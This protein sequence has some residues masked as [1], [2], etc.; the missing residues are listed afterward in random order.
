MTQK[1]SLFLS[2][3]VTI[4]V[5]AIILLSTIP[6]GIFAVHIYETDSIDMH[7][8]RAIAIA[9]S[10]ASLINPDEFLLALETGEKNQYYMELQQK[11]N[12]AKS[13][14][15]ALFLFSG[16]A[17]NRGDF[18]AFMQGLTPTCIPVVGFGDVIPSEAGVFPPELM[19]AQRGLAV[20]TGI[21]P[22]GVDENYIVAAY[23]PIFNQNGSPIGIV[24]VNILATEV[25]QKGNNFAL[26]ITL[27]VVVVIAILVWIPIFWVKKY[28][29]KPLDDLK[30]AAQQISD[31]NL[32]ANFDTNRNDEIGILS[33]AFSSMQT[34]ISN[35]M[36]EIEITNQEIS[37]GNLVRSN[38]RFSAKGD[39]QKMLD[40]IENIAENTSMYLDC[41]SCGIV[42]FDLE[43]RFAFIN[44]YNRNQGFDPAFMLGKTINEVLPPAEANFIGGKLKES[45][46]KGITVS[47]PIDMPLPDGTVIHSE[48]T[49]MPI[50]NA[51]GKTI[52]YMN[53]AN[54]VT[55]RV[56]AESRSN[57]I[58]AYQASAADS[59]TQVLTDGLAKGVLQFD[60][61]L[62]AYD[63]DTASSSA[64]Y[65]QIGDM[66]DQFTKKIGGCVSEI[67]HLL[68]EFASEN[69]DVSM[70]AEYIGDF[71]I[72]KQSLEKVTQSIGMLVSEIQNST[73]QLETGAFQISQ[74]T[75]SLMSSFEEQATTMNQVKDAV[76]TL[77]E[78]TQ[79]NAGDAKNASGLSEQVQEVANTGSQH[80]Q[81]MSTLMEEIKLSSA[82]IGKVATIIEDIAFQ[83]NLLALN[84]S[85]EAA[86]AGE[87]GKG[88]AVVAEEVRNL[89]GRSSEAARNTA[90]M[91]AKSLN[92]VN[93]GVA[94]SEETAEALNKILKV[95]SSVTEVISSIARASNEQAEEISIIQNSIEAIHKSAADNA[96]AVQSNASVSEELSSQANILTALVDRFKI[97]K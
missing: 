88:F 86:R 54:D 90:E 35:V 56:R 69:F 84:A 91:I 79:K 21:I 10:L 17:N 60:Y 70:D 38:R 22:S 12:R 93:E 67:S 61:T 87:H 81:D 71:V 58:N 29:G 19:V 23:A 72:I 39:F 57:K 83:T 50:R 42:I 75:Q 28:I 59:I 89:A 85:V 78:K 62:Q 49:M 11:F 24:G 18:H 66:L 65:K 92:R 63:E 74:S 25:L 40:G 45:S 97:K 80:M 5:L 8:S 94:K 46:S 27:I 20:S 51:H 43:Y 95:T 68:Q 52:A 32:T 64:S 9:Q 53:I 15:G 96:T 34:V 55:S 4:M 82:E 37:A 47:Y 30:E 16:A 48:H 36:N 76:S 1:K 33:Q 41:M 77:T 73:S 13:D 26:T 2:T 6:I 7:Q 31:G 44:S 3:K 14:L